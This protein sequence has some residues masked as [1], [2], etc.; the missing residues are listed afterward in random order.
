MAMTITEK[1]NKIAENQP[2]VFEAGKHSEWSAFWDAC[3][4]NGHRTS[5]TNGFCGRSWNDTT[6][7]PKYNI[8][9]EGSI[10]YMFRETGI[11]DIKSIC[12]QQ[13]ISLD[14]SLVTS[15]EMAF[16]N[17]KITNMGIFDG[18]SVN[19]FYRFFYGANQL[20]S[21]DK[22]ILRDDGTQTFNQPFADMPKLKNITIEG[23]IGQSGFDLRQSPL[24]SKESIVS[25]INALSATT[26]GLTVTLSK[27]AVNKAFET[28]EGAKDGTTSTEWQTLI[29]T[30]SNWTINLA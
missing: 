25:I 12:E 13:N 15:G 2:K 28:S 9:P 23:V 17:A 18:R 8:K 6:F 19:N 30:K 11:T 5:Y 3:Q 7:K 10:G 27:T 20:V 26:S 1:L 24:L 16:Q 14:F 21:L 22:L 29:A 4:E